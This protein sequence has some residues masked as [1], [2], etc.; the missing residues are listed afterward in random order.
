MRTISAQ[1]IDSKQPHESIFECYSRLN[2]PHL[3]YDGAI[4]AE[5]F[6]GQ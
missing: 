4:H 1:T 3:L 2:H 5:V 6:A